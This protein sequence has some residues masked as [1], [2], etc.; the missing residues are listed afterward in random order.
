MSRLEMPT[1]FMAKTWIF[2]V[3]AIVFG[4]L[5]S[6]GLIMGPL[7]LFG[8]V[9][10]VNGAPAI[11]AGVGLTAMSVPFLLVFALAVYN[12][13]A[14]RRPLLRLC[15][16]GIE[17]VEIGSSSLDGIP[18]IPGLI[19][20][21]WLI[22]STQG[23]RR[24]VVLVPWRNFQD[25]RVSGPPMARRL[26]IHA[27]Q[28]LGTAEELPRNSLVIDQIVLEE[29]M[30]S[31]PLDQIAEAIQWYANGS[32]DLEDLASWNDVELTHV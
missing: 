31:T 2:L 25:A 26:T 4:G 15:R 3:Q 11:D 7:S 24:R 6:F 16:E 10:D 29:V 18:L 32:T 30:F 22:L 1:Q 5:A 21:A 23:F 28:S 20:L 19:R 17:I 14:R 13:R 9:H 12:I 8:F 27:R